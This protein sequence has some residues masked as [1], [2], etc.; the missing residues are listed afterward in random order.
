M[1]APD[2]M[3]NGAGVD[4]SAGGRSVTSDSDASTPG[5]PNREKINTL[6]GQKRRQVYMVQPSH[7]SCT[8]P[9][10]G[11][12]CGVEFPVPGPEASMWSQ[13]RFES[14]RL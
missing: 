5:I 12:R 14:A 7:S 9:G 8:R 2:N 4:I 13:Y 1:A 10:G 6:L 3:P 11:F